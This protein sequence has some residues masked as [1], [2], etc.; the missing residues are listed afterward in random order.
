MASALSS[1]TAFAA[2][3]LS[4]RRKAN[5]TS[6][7]AR[8][9]YRLATKA[10]F[11][12]PPTPWE[13]TAL[14][15]HMTP[16][17]IDYHWDKHH[18]AYVNNLNGQVKDTPNAGKDLLTL[19][20]EGYNGGDLA[21]FFNNAAQIWNHTFFWE[22]IKPSGGGKPTGKIAELIDRDFGSYE[23]FAKQ[24][25]TAGATQF[26]SGWAWLVE[27]GGK[28]K[29]TKTPNAVNPLCFEGQKPLLTVD[30]WEH[31]YYID[32]KNLRPK[33]LNT[34]LESLVNWDAV[35]ARL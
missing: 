6:R 8:P 18:R 27:E 7:S 5:V 17:Q 24:F 21:P 30:V 11:T 22:S 28:L 31:A 16:E 19:I 1:S 12:L 25:T 23:E 4:L 9:S 33:F 35:N 29:V 3:S 13:H 26:G 34:F 15:P 14:V 2:G 32:Y 20:K 10:E